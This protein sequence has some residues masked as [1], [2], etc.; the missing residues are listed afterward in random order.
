MKRERSRLGIG[1]SKKGSLLDIMWIGLV[2]F[3]FAVLTI[4]GGYILTEVSS[5]FGNSTS[6]GN[7]SKQ[8]LRENEDRLPALF[9]G[10][11]L[12]MFIGSMLATV[13]SVFWIKTHPMFFFISIIMVIIFA[14]IFI[15]LGDMFG[16]VA[17]TTE[18]QPT[19]QRFSIMTHIMDHFGTYMLVLAFIVIIVL[20]VKPPGAQV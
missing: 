10:I 16:D 15:I 18:F 6:I 11:F 8:M 4:V 14:F 1:A 20:F 17:N 9:D 2:L 12:F 13:I 3:I 19:A 5:N 7:E